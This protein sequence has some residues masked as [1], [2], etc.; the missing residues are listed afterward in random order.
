MSLMINLIHPWKKLT[1]NL[2]SVA[3]HY[4]S[5]DYKPV[6]FLMHYCIASS[7]LWKCQLQAVC[8]DLTTFYQ[9]LVY[10]QATAE[11]VSW[12]T[13]TNLPLHPGHKFNTKKQLVF[14][15]LWYNLHKQHTVAFLMPIMEGLV[16][17]LLH[18]K[19]N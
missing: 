4:Y 18:T 5:E 3:L 19:T 15:A 2:W 12:F 11:T 16:S 1:P 6:I 17:C 8:M 7:F 10:R 13:S 9:C 14:D